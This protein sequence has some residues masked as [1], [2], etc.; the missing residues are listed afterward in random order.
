MDIWSVGVIAHILITGCPPFYGRT[1]QDIYRSIISDIPKFGKVR[2][3][4]SP[5][6]IQFVMKCLSKDPRH[7]FSAQQLLN[8]SWLQD[9]CDEIEVD[10]DAASDIIQDMAAFRKQNVFQTGVVSLLTALK[11]SS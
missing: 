2:T 11:V 7:R 3:Q 10:E 1:K 5:E 9:N 8:H 6:S 4:L